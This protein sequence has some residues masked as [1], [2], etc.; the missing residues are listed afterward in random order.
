[1]N[2]KIGNAHSKEEFQKKYQEIISNI[3]NTLLTL[4]SPKNNPNF[5]SKQSVKQSANKE[6]CTVS[7][8]W[9]RISSKD[10]LRAELE[11]KL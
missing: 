5:I 10:K 1:L 11:Q 8:R 3:I 9:G 7:F 4:R 2:K 6:K